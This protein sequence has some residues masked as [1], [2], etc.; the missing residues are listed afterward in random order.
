[1]IK[2]H[3]SLLLRRLIT[4]SKKQKNNKVSPGEFNKTKVSP[5]CFC[6]KKKDSKYCVYKR[7][8][9]DI[10]LTIKSKCESNSLQC[11]QEVNL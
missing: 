2:G 3:H 11:Q 9:K 5:E 4:S 6:K 7:R 1:M 10:D 8:R